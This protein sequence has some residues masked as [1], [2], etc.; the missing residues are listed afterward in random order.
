MK[1][2]NPVKKKSHKIYSHKYAAQFTTGR[3]LV[4]TRANITETSSV[5][6]DLYMRV[7]VETKSSRNLTIKTETKFS[8][9]K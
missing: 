5:T 9:R 2:M 1:Q 4:K 6:L 7:N 3:K 8:V